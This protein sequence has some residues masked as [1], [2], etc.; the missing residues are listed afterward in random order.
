[1]A[2]AAL[3]F[4]KSRVVLPPAPPAA[5]SYQR[6]VVR[7]GVG[8]VSGQ[9][10]I[11]DGGLAW[12]GRVGAEL[13]LLQGREAAALAARNV[14]AQIHLA[15]KGWRRFGGLLRVE[16]HVASAEDFFQQPAVLDGASELFV[17]A[18]GEPLGRHARTAYHAARLPL[19]APV[20]LAVTFALR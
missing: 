12:R 14:L 15:L 2:D 1:M 11:L 3:R 18:L 9:F 4:D 16:G 6:V 20:E 19:D 8:F 7:R 17:R 13:T 10:P 5:G